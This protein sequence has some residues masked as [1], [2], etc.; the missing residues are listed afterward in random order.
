MANKAQ[1]IV[2]S[3]KITIQTEQLIIEMSK[4]VY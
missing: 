1:F 4:I 2:K 3:I